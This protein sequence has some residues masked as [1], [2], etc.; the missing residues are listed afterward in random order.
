MI[1]LLKIVIMNHAKKSVMVDGGWSSWEEWGSCDISCGEGG[2]R[3]RMRE[4]EAT[5]DTNTCQLKKCP[6]KEKA[7]GD[8]DNEP[9]KEQCKGGWTLWDSWGSCDITCGKG[10]RQERFRICRQ[11]PD[12][13]SCQ[14]QRCPGKNN[15]FGECDLEPCIKCQGGWTLWERWGSC[16]RGKRER[17]RRC[18]TT[19]DTPLCYQRRCM[20][21]PNNFGNCWPFKVVGAGLGVLQ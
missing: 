3:E 12:T 15:D 20:G 14:L 18:W 13:P 21:K 5:P 1:K 7:V 19:P 16:D 17:V 10:G 8:C 6:G 9:C 4:C 2:R 11:T